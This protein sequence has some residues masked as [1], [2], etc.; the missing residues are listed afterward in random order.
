MDKKFNNLNFVSNY[1]PIFFLLKI[2]HL[3]MAGNDIR[4]IHCLNIYSLF[5]T[6]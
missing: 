4:E 5:L 6:L 3:E 2:F 1:E